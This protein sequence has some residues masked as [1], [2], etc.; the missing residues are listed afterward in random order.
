MKDT[1]MM[2]MMMMITLMTK[3]KIRGEISE[4]KVKRK[5]H[6]S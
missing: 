2:M 1:M 4:Q 5:L 3:S 6:G